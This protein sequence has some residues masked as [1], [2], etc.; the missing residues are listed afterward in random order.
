MCSP[1]VFGT[2]QGSFNFVFLA[3]YQ[4]FLVGKFPNVVG[5]FN[6]Q[7][8]EPNVFRVCKVSTKILFLSSTRNGCP[9]KKISFFLVGS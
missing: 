9:L 4:V 2:C 6:L 7:E 3:F 1:F 5:A 8:L